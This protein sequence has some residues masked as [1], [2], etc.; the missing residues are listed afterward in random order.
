MALTGADLDLLFN[1][2]KTFGTQGQALD[3]LIKALTK[4]V[5]GTRA[6]WTGSYAEKFRSEWTALQPKFQSFVQ[7]L[8]DASSDINSNVK[9]ISAATGTPIHG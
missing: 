6:T 8:T 9:A 7:T 5:D 1:T 2:G 4:E 3:Q